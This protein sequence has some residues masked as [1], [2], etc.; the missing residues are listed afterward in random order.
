MEKSSWHHYTQ[1]KL[2]LLKS[3]LETLLQII[4]TFDIILVGPQ[5]PDPI[6]EDNIYFGHRTWRIQDG[7][8]QESTSLLAIFIELEGA[9]QA[10]EGGSH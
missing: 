9:I 3:I 1:N 2:Q 5:E 4:Q 7:T 6:A 8:D 10:P